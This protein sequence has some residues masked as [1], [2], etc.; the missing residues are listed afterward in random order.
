MLLWKSLC[1]RSPVNHFLGIVVFCALRVC[2]WAGFRLIH[3]KDI[4][5]GI[6]GSDMILVSSCYTW[7]DTGTLAGS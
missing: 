1:G 4:A 5:N 6:E 2:P 3:I 7:K